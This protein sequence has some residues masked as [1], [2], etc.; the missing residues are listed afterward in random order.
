MA[1]NKEKLLVQLRAIFLHCNEAAGREIKISSDGVEIRHPY[2]GSSTVSINGQ[3]IKITAE[4]F[5]EAFQYYS[6]NGGVKPSNYRELSAPGI[7]NFAYEINDD[8]VV[9][10]PKRNPAHCIDA[11][12]PDLGDGIAR[13]RSLYDQSGVSV[14]VPCEGEVRAGNVMQALIAE[15]RALKLPTQTRYLPVHDRYYSDRVYSMDALVDVARRTDMPQWNVIQVTEADALKFASKQPKTG[16]S[17]VYVFSMSGRSVD[18]WIRGLAALED[19]GH[20]IVV[21]G[22]KMDHSKSVGKLGFT[23]HLTPRISTEDKFENAP[24]KIYGKLSAARAATKKP[25]TWH[26]TTQGVADAFVT[27]EAPRGMTGAKRWRKPPIY[28]HGPIAYSLGDWNPIAAFVDLPDGRT[29]LFTGRDGELGG[30]KAGTVSGALGDIRAAS[31][32]KKFETF[33]LEELHEILTWGDEGLERAASKCSKNEALWP[34]SAQINVEKLGEWIE[35]KTAILQ[36]EI[37]EALKTAVPTYRKSNAYFAVAKHAELRNRLVETFD[38][39]LPPVADVEEYLD[40]AKYHR[41]TAVE[42]QKG[43]EQKKRIAAAEKRRE[44]ENGATFEM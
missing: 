10:K 37:V 34:K 43:L 20:P 16:E 44:T 1:E 29:A 2:Y 13:L 31:S 38:I 9:L 8:V 15:R 30:T 35:A 14:F 17:N 42:R 32:H 12:V 25:V 18:S 6:R 26:S 11:V 33:H 36:E 41:D 7:G 39:D 28:F 23:S 3:P 19:R 4:E 24:W 27:R 21:F 40:L 22:V 5:K